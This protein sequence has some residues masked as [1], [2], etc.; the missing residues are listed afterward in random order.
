MTQYQDQKIKLITGASCP[1]GSYLAGGAVNSVFT[2][3]RIADYDFYFRDQASFELAIASAFENSFWCAHVSDRSVTFSDN[4]TIHQYMFFEFFD[5]AD[6]VFDAFD[7]TVCMGAYDTDA[8]DFVLHE[9]FLTDCAERKLR[10]HPGTRFP[11]ISALRVLKYQDRGYAIS[12]EDMLQLA[13][14]CA[15]LGMGSW[16]DLEAQ[17][18]GIYGDRIRIVR[19]GE[20]TVAKAIEAIS[21]PGAIGSGE[22]P[23]PPAYCS[24][25]FALLNHLRKGW[26][27]P[28]LK[29]EEE[30][31]ALE[32]AE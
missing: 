29:D 12:R 31:W 32:A 24:S 19:D 3:R 13:L 1:K 9:K 27:Q 10:F 22:K 14:A 21:K 7:F 30:M 28:E 11:L 18:G 8:K 23:E 6:G 20:F 17:I 16:E 15:G 26:G 5:K 25:S 4:G 2:G